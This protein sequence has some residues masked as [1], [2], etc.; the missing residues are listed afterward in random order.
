MKY[1]IFALLLMSFNVFANKTEGLWVSGVGVSSVAPDIATI[2]FNVS[3]INK[4]AK[5]AQKQNAQ[6][7]KKVI[8]KVKSLGVAGK[9][10]QS[11]QFSVNAEYDYKDRTRVLRGHRVTH[12]F[13]AILRK[14]DS[15]GDVLD[16]ITESGQESISIGQISFGLSKDEELKLKTLAAS[17]EHAKS[18][19]ET[20]AKS[21]GKKLGEITFIDEVA[22]VSPIPMARMEMMKTMSADAS[23]EV[24]TG[25]VGISAKV[26][27]HFNLK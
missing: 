16:A 20:L 5:E 7:T 4:S 11:S 13:S 24:Q 21:A 6:V 18:K 15:L 23:T 9:D 10:L 17:I 26:R 25:E 8:A 2:S 1:F 3:T 14:V 19:A 12:G 22:E 27:V